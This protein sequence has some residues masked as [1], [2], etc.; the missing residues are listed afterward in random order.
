MGSGAVEFDREAR[1]AYCADFGCAIRA[2]LKGFDRPG[3]CGAD[4]ACGDGGDV[5]VFAADGAAGEAAKHGELAGVGE[6]VSDGA[7]EESLGRSLERGGG[8]QVGIESGECGEEALL[9][10]GPV[11]GLRV[12][13]AL[14]ALG[15]GERPMEQVAH[16]GED[17]DGAA[18]GA[19]EVGEGGGRVF[20]GAG[21][22]VSK[23]GEGVAKEL[24]FFVHEKNLGARAVRMGEL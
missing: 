18:A 3:L 15:N 19:V 12:L 2:K 4:L 6:R 9:F 8:S 16:V 11:E 5:E 10:R 24:P 20:K 23:R 13:P 22:A 7:L 21:G 1:T 17:L 14:I